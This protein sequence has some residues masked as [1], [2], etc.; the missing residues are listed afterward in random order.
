MYAEAIAEFQKALGA[1]PGSPFALGSL[2]HAYAASG[3][4]N[5]ARRTLWEMLELSKRRY[6]SPFDIAVVYA[7]M[8]DN[9]R[10][11]DWLQ[12]ALDDHS[13]EM[14]FLKVDPRFD[15]LHGEPRF[16]ELLRRIGL[17]S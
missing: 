11:L 3:E 16:A 1:S 2:G 6:V 15:R 9:E 12:K 4:R 17:S 5:K 10:T 8:D 14:I 7:G 13:L